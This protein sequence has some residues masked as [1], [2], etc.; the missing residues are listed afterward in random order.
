MTRKIPLTALEI[1]RMYTGFL[2]AAVILFVVCSV[3]TEFNPMTLIA[4]GDAFWEFITQDFLPPA[5]P[6]A[7][8]IPGIFSSILVTLALAMS[9]T[10]VAAVLAF[11]VSLFG[12]EKVSPFPRAA[13]AVRGFATFL[14]NIPALVWA[15]ILFSSLGIGTGVGFVALCITSFAFMV[16]AFVET[17]E[18]V[19]QDCVE[20]LQAVGASFPQRVSQ[21]ILPSCLSGFLSWFLYCVEVNIRA[22]TIVGMVGGGGVGYVISNSLQGYDYG[23]A[24]VAI[25]LVFLVAYFIERIFVRIK[26]KFY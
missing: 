17:M 15:F 12:S 23:T 10:T 5:L 3:L 22:S 8:R 20:S 11:F 13:K 14:R 9:S 26:K 1:R 6:K 21:A 24:G 2:I 4:D 16:R 19:S 25:L 18:D 7:S